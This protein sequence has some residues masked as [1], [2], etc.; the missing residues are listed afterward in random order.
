MFAWFWSASLLSIRFHLLMC[1]CFYLYVCTLYTSGGRC[2]TVW[3]TM[4]MFSMQNYKLFSCHSFVFFSKHFQY[5]VDN[6]IFCRTVVFRQKWV[7]KIQKSGLE[8]TRRCSWT[9]EF[10]KVTKIFTNKEKNKKKSKN[11]CKILFLI[12]KLFFCVFLCDFFGILS[13]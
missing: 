6:K 9:S 1:M 7:R 4:K 8:P 3:N 5:I 12:Y 13:M 2:E 10:T 11:V